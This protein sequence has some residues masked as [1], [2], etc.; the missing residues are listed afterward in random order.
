MHAITDRFFS[1]ADRVIERFGGSIDKHIGDCVMAVF[2]APVAHGNDAER[3]VRAALAIRD[4]MPALA[5][6]IGCA[7]DTHVGIASGQVVASRG[8]GHRTYSITGES[9]NLA[10]RLTDQAAA[11]TILVSD[12]VRHLLADRLEHAEVDAFELKGMAGPV[13]AF[14]VIA[15]HEAR[16]PG[17]PFVGRRGELQQLESALAACLANGRGQTVHVRGE[18]GIGKSRLLEELQRHA[19][20]AGFACHKGLVLDFGAG[21]GQ[22]ATSSLVRGVLELTSASDELAAGAAIEAAIR[23][24]LI[25]ADRRVFLNDLLDLPQPTELRALY[26]AM[27]NRARRQGREDA[28]CRACRARQPKGAS[29]RHRRGRPLGGRPDP[30]PSGAPG[31]DGRCRAR[32]AGHD[33]APGRRSARPGLALGHRRQPSSDARPRPPARRRGQRPGARLRRCQR[34]VRAPLRRPGRRQ[35]AVPRP[36]AAPRRGRCGRR[37]ARLGAEPGAGASRP[38]AAGRPAGPAGRIRA[39][40]NV[41]PRTRSVSCWASRRT[42]AP[43]SYATCWSSRSATSSCSATR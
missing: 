28:A 16:A 10:S 6:E 7:L 27:D 1:L 35:P 37:R 9:V 8:A 41:S 5:R 15:L 36:A 21:A 31:A 22:D 30:R 32:G 2:G 40:A 4:A 3:A 24:G 20:G 43:I 33:L 17:R 11:G 29:A 42:T 25:A 39:S 23:N 38:S 19:A 18:A 14:R 13:R 34:R 26:D 12:P